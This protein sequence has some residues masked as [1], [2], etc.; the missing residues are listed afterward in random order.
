MQNK[1][2]I[3]FKKEQSND[4]SLEDLI[5][6]AFIRSF[7]LS[8]INQLEN[9]IQK[10]EGI[11]IFT[12]CT[13]KNSYT[14]IKEILSGEKNKI[15]LNGKL[16]ESLKSLLQIDK[17][18]SDFLKEELIPANSLKP[19]LSI[20]KLHYKKNCNYLKEFLKC[21]TQ[22]PIWRYD[23]DL[24]WNN[25]F[26]GNI[27]NQNA[28]LDLSHYC[29]SDEKKYIAYIEN[30]FSEKVPLISEFQIKNNIIL[31]INR[32][33]SVVDLPEWKI[34]EDFISCGYFSNFCC[35]PF[36]SE[37]SINEK[38]LITMRLD[39]DEDIESATE[40]FEIYKKNKLPISLAITTNQI[41]N[42]E[43]KYELPKKVINFGGTI[44]NHSHT[45]PTNWGNTKD[46]II[47]EIKTS[48]RIIEESFG[49]KNEFAVSPFHH[50]TWDA[51]EIL[52]EMGF[53][54]VVA[55]ISSSHH[56]F[57]TSRGGLIDEKLNILFHSQQCMI[58]GDCLS[59]QRKID[60]Y[61]YAFSLFSKLGFSTGFLDHPISPRY[62]YGWDSKNRQVNSHK[63]IIEFLLEEQI[64][65]VSQEEMFDRLKFKEILEVEN[66]FV[67]NKYFMEITNRSKYVLSITLNNKKYDCNPFSKTSLCIQRGE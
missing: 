17:I 39:C 58:H 56:E 7:G 60:D 16:N 51:L 54:G 35:V 45:H 27:L 40:V 30:K 53:K 50:L 10:K 2:N 41:V 24:E 28:M 21:I 48:K 1:L 67:N 23:F 3:Y 37:F 22:R 26:Y 44:L 57:L 43:M 64:K 18:N 34:I 32:N 6:S 46:E 12:E 4:H 14:N 55:G 66:N 25:H 33:L 65:F 52:E 59:P 19:S 62:D 9:P 36:L 20:S 15:I 8:Q 13:S 38:G 47:N 11:H 49:I 31:W 42:N 29:R 61:L 5:F 63:K